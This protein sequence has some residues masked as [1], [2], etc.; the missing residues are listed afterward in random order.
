MKTLKRR[1]VFMKI[2]TKVND[3]IEKIYRTIGTI[4]MMV[5]IAVVFSSVIIRNVFKNPMLWSVEVSI[6]C[7]IW[8]IFL[9]AAIAVRGRR[10][11]VVEVIPTKYK[12]TNLIFDI[13]ADIISYALIYVMIVN[14]VIFAKMGTA[15][16]AA[17]VAGAGI[18]GWLIASQIG[19]IS[20]PRAFKSILPLIGLTLLI[21]FSGIVFPDLFLFIPKLIMPEFV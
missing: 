20:A 11:Y 18:V 1:G 7:F 9:G 21:I 4:L 12:K 13:I 5:L 15:T 14:G 19:E 3:I 10:H 6:I 2:L 17:A 16:E 8:M